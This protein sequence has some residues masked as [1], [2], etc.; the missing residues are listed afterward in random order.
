MGPMAIETDKLSAL[1]VKTLA[2]VFRALMVLIFPLIAC[3]AS[4]AAEDVPVVRAN[5][6]RDTSYS[7]ETG[8][9]TKIVTCE[10]ATMSAKAR[11]APDVL[12]DIARSASASGLFSLDT[13]KNSIRIEKTTPTPEKPIPTVEGPKPIVAL[14][15]LEDEDA[16]VAE[17]Q[18]VSSCYV[19]WFEISTGGETQRIYWNCQASYLEERKEIKRLIDELAP[20]LEKLPKPRCM[21]R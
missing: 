14:S 4:V 1:F 15:N 17:V 3:S 2:S 21:F 11:I 6:G 19:S 10:G 7:S 12:E 18:V 13:S 9:V 20:F 5:F 16:E 8:L